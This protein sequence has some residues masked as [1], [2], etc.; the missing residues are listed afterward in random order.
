M[1]IQVQTIRTQD[2]TTEYFRFGH[3]PEPLVILPGLSVQSVMG[4]ADAVAQ[5]Y[6]LL[7]DDYTIYVLDRRKALPAEYP[8]RAMAQDTAQTLHALGLERVRLFGASQGGMI[9]MQIAID[10]PQLVQKLVLGSAAAC[11]TAQ[12]YRTVG[13]WV[14]LAEE[15]RME[16]LY[17]AFGQALYPPDV[18]GRLRAS[19]AAAAK[20]VTKEEA[21]RFICLAQGLK[22]FDV[23]RQLH[24]IVCPTLVIGDTDDRVMGADAAAQIMECLG[25]RPDCAL[26]MYEGYGHAVYDTAADFPERLL[27]FLK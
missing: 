15:G 5:A 1:P 2:C 19:F 20:T 25:G 21:A 23:T 13:Q 12:R 18:F 14:R 4:A 9:A 8:I 24:R 6:R 7:T 22:G 11:M 3:G 17:D 26:Y 27:R 16:E 10:R